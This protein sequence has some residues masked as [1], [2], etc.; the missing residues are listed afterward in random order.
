MR[1]LFFNGVNTVGGVQVLVSHN[2]SHLQF[3]L[4]VVRNPG[5]APTTSL[6]N[7]F[8]HP[9]RHDP[10]RD[11]LRAGMAPRVQGLFRSGPTGTDPVVTN[12]PLTGDL[13]VVSPTYT[14]QLA[15]FVSHVHL[16]HINLLPSVADD[17]PVIVGQDTEAMI[18]TLVAVGDLPRIGATV[19]TVAPRQSFMVG[20]LNCQP[21]P[22]DHDLPGANGV[23]V[24]TPSGNLAYTGDWRHHGAHPERMAAFAEACRDQ[25][26]DVLLTEASTIKPKPA[27][28]QLSE[29]QLRERVEHLISSTDGL[30]GIGVH[31]ANL[32]RIAALAQAAERNDRNLV[33]TSDTAR[34]MLA[35][36]DH[37]IV[38]P[39]IM[40]DVYVAEP[41]EDG[42]LI[43][44][45]A[46]TADEV[47]G[48]KQAFVCESQPATWYRLLDY[49][50]GPDDLYIHAN[51]APYGGRDPAWPTLLTWAQQ[52]R[53]RFEVLEAHGHALPDDLEWLVQTI[54]PSAVIP[55]HTNHPHLFPDGPWKTVLPE[56]GESIW[57]NH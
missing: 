18:N 23:L 57:L 48:D 17:V 6:F 19:E 26:V 51:G 52:L 33:L 47:A 15:A 20:D 9:R 28:P 27:R 16:D 54:G 53:V 29:P 10:L 42:T 14:A 46:V 44:L 5:I 41:D 30:V 4:G 39:G 21:M 2:K 45:T 50:L 34:R 3:D 36:R 49:G 12:P 56:R 35:A 13:P 25:K 1:L 55:V 31:T 22:V 37:G 24:T 7:D 8:V 40:K 32:D 43:D 38:E 11:Y